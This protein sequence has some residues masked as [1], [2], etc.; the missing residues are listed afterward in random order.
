MIKIHDEELETVN[1]GSVVGGI[2]ETVGGGFTAAAGGPA[3]WIAG[4]VLVVDGVTTVISGIK[5]KNW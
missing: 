1:G 2:L 5:E 4:G 3:G